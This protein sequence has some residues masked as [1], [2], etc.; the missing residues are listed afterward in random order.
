MD[1]LK[2]IGKKTTVIFSTHILSDVERICDRV[3]VI[4]G[5][6]IAMLGTL[7]ELRARH[8]ADSILVEFASLSDKDK[9]AEIAESLMEKAVS[10]ETE[11]T[12]HVT[13]ISSAQREVLRILSANDILPLKVEVQEP[14]IES[15]FLEVS[16]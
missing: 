11:I 2:Q 5:G 8:K 16:Q 15:L 12:L 9:F 4:S 10:A 3:A 14:T 6:N 7:A 13:D 1:I